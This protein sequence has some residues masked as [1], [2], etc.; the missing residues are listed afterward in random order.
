ME[1]VVPSREG[2][3]RVILEKVQMSSLRKRCY[4]IS[5]RWW[6]H[7]VAYMGWETPD[8]DYSKI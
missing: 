8:N 5:R 4:L 7:F 2:Q 1:R 6:T 3:G